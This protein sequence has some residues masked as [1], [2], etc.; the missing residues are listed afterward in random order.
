MNICIKRAESWLR[1]HPK[2]KQWAWF[3]AL[4]CGGLFV[5]AALSY[6]IKLIIHYMK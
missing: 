1:T 3:A 2:V 4:W 6:P 5:A